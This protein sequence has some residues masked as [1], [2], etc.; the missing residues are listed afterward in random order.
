MLKGDPHLSHHQHGVIKWYGWE[1]AHRVMWI[2]VEPSH[3][4]LNAQTWPKT[5]L[6]FTTG[7]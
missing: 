3:L 5:A 2:W 6:P 4:P 1:H 7:T